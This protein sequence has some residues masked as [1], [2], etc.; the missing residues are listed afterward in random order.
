MGRLRRAGRV[1]DLRVLEVEAVLH[2]EVGA[3]AGA[4]GFR[5]S[6]RGRRRG[7]RRR[8]AVPPARGG[9]Q[10]G[11]QAAVGR[12][13]RRWRRGSP[14]RCSSRRRSAGRLHRRR[15]WLTP[16]WGRSR[17]MWRRAPPQPTR[18][19]GRRRQPP[20][21]AGE[22]PAPLAAVRQPFAEA[23]PPRRSSTLSVTLPATAASLDSQRA[24]A[25]RTGRPVYRGRSP[26]CGVP[27][28]SG[29]AVGVP[30][31]PRR[32]RGPGGRQPA[33]TPPTARPRVAATPATASTHTMSRGAVRLSDG[34]AGLLLSRATGGNGSHGTLRLAARFAN[35]CLQSASVDRPLGQPAG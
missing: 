6:P 30:T 9:G 16:D 20:R 33:G 11:S 3:P 17:P 1:G 31:T 4:R 24:A 2:H 25:G 35:T 12:S 22:L 19:S 23:P 29:W 7:R 13:R 8:G 32:R 27:A 14:A 15:G 5:S 26:R 34:I 18:R 21:A 10:R 28:E